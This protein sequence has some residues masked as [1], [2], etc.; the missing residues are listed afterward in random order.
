MTTAAPVRFE[1]ITQDG[2]V[3]LAFAH[4][5]DKL[6]LD[7]GMAVELGKGMIDAAVALG[8]HV[9]IQVPPRQVTNEQRARLTTRA[10]HI[11]R[12]MTQQDKQPARIAVEVVDTVLAEVA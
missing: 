3:K 5:I 6:V 10:A 8:W 1:L 2:K 7:P 11:I 12:S 9:E 4:A